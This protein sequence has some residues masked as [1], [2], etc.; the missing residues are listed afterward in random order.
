[1]ESRVQLK[2]KYIDFIGNEHDERQEAVDSNHDIQLKFRK[3]IEEE[4]I[5]TF[6][7]GMV[8]KLGTTKELWESLE[9]TPKC[10]K[11]IIKIMNKD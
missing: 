6:S 2:T 1:M 7:D 5:M 8:D 3:Y 10:I 11:N 4:L 9:F